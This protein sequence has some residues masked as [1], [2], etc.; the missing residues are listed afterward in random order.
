[1]EKG[2]L[3]AL[4]IG[5][6]LVLAVFIFAVVQ[7]MQGCDKVTGKFFWPW[8]WSQEKP[9]VMKTQMSTEGSGEKVNYCEDAT[10]GADEGLECYLVEKKNWWGTL[11][12]A[13]ICEEEYVYN[14]DTACRFVYYPSIREGICI[15]DCPPG[16]ICKENKYATPSESCDCWWDY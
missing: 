15:G 16:M 13:C 4:Q 12:D 7:D 8:P 5:G 1:M 6:V 3:T 11:Y 2:A 10:C 9:C 14:V